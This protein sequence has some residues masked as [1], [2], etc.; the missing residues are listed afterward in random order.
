MSEELKSYLIQYR[1]LDDEIHALNTKLTK[2]RET[3]RTVELNLEVVLKD[4]AFADVGKLELGSTDDY[5]SVKRTW[6]KAWSL[7][8]KDLKQMLPEAFKTGSADECYEYIVREKKRTLCETGI[9]L[10]RVTK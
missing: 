1:T 2:L 6:N 5:I 7:S 10:T 4:S 3:K 8:Q 9:Q